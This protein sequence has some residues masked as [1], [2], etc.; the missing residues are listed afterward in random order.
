MAFTGSAAKRPAL[1][2]CIAGL[3][4]QPFWY[5]SAIA[6]EQ[7]GIVIVCVPY[8]IAWARGYYVFWLNPT[9]KDLL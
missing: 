3:L 1:G 6:A 4:S 8:T 5:Y 7:W 2:T 9:R